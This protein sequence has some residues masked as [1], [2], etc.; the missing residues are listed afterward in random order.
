VA[1]PEGSTYPEPG[2]HIEVDEG[3]ARL[4]QAI[5]RHGLPTTNSCQN[6]FA[7][8]SEEETGEV[9]INFRTVEAAQSFATIIGRTVRG[10]VQTYRPS[11]AEGVTV[12]FPVSRLASVE[13]LFE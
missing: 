2:G 8:E 5:W 3:L 1:V 9:H 6:A 4:L 13:G 12:V 11:G 10:A 7:P